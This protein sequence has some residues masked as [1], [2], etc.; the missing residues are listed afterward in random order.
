MKELY[1]VLEAKRVYAEALKQLESVYQKP[2]NIEEI[3]KIDAL[4]DEID[5]VTAPFSI[6][7]K[8][9]KEIVV[10]PIAT[11]VNTMEFLTKE[12]KMQ[13]TKFLQYYKKNEIVYRIHGF[14]PQIEAQILQRLTNAGLIEESTAFY[15]PTC[16]ETE[17]TRFLNHTQIEELRILLDKEIEELTQEQIKRLDYYTYSCNND[18]CHWTDTYDSLRQQMILEKPLIRKAYTFVGILEYH[19]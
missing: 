10:T 8:I 16:G 7:S 12:Q 5:D 14:I 11:I 4:I 17:L 1:A 2:T 13:L 18:E 3:K 15:C 19:E 9:K 6:L